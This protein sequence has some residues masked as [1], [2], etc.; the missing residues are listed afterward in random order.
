MAR[1]APTVSH[2]SSGELSDA[3]S[4]KEHVLLGATTIEL[5]APS[6]DC[7]LTLAEAVSFSDFETE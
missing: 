6:S 3:G 5:I 2:G 4:G 1:S 7:S